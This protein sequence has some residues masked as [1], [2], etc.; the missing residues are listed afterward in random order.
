MP[1]YEFEYYIKNLIDI[2]EEK[3]TGKESESHDAAYQKTMSDAK[4]MLPKT[5]GYSLKKF[6]GIPSS[7]KMS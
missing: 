3:K 5:S 2:L 4:K 7:L 6:P 1:Y